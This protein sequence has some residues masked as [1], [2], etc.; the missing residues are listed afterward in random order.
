MRH[1][2][3][4]AFLVAL[5]LVAPQ[6]GWPASDTAFVPTRAPAPPPDCQAHVGYDRDT[7]LPGYLL[8]TSLG[9]KTCIPFTTVAAHPPQGY[10]GDF[11][12][13]EFTDAKLREQWEACKADAECYQRVQKQVSGRH[14][15]NREY[16]FT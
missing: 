6:R 5:F 16:H 12:V 10:Q 3:S 15:P 11:Y 1:H 8:P 7:M 9:P 2:F 4:K 14:P 13:D